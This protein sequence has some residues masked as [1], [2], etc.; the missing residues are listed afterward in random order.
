MATAPNAILRLK[1]TDLSS[2]N[3][4]TTNV[5]TR[6]SLQHTLETLLQKLR[7]KLNPPSGSYAARKLDYLYV[8]VPAYQESNGKGQIS[9]VES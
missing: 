9:S 4:I 1:P 3:T 2:S 5:S 8:H 7:I 6:N